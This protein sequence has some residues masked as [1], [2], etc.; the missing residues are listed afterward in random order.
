MLSE[1]WSAITP[2]E[3]IVPLITALGAWLAAS[4]YTRS[5]ERIAEKSRD[6]VIQERVHDAKVARDEDLTKRFTLLMNSY[7]KKIDELTAEI[8]ELRVRVE[9]CEQKWRMRDAAT[10][11]TT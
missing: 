10:A 2:R 8:Q 3:I 9:A 6:D 4:R 1:M 5:N 11:A 7:E